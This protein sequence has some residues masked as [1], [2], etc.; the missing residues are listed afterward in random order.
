[1]HQYRLETDL[2]E[3]RSA[4]MDLGFLVNKLP[5]SQQCVL[6]AKKA[7]GILGCI[8]NIIANRLREVILTHCSAIARP[9]LEHCVQFGAP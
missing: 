9:H 2:L 8:R 7:S 4:D 5:M 1:M 6:V 3:S